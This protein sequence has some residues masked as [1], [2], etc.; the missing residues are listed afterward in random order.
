MRAALLI[1]ILS[2]CGSSAGVEPA[3][4][5][6]LKRGPDVC[7]KEGDDYTCSHDKEVIDEEI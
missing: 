6:C 5:P 3:I 4:D 2:G 1:L 7:V